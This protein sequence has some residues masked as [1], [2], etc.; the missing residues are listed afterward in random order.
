M[1]RGTIAP[2]TAWLCALA[3][4]ATA[5]QTGQAR[6]TTSLTA[7]AGVT[8]AQHTDQSASPLLFAGSGFAERLDYERAG[9]RWTTTLGISSLIR[10]DVSRATAAAPVRERS[11]QGGLAWTAVRPLIDRARA[12]LAAG[13]T[14]DARGTLLAHHYDDPAATV[15]WFASAFATVG[16]A[17]RWRWMV[18]GGTAILRAS[19]PLVGVAHRPY[20]D[21]RIEQAAPALR[22]VTVSD[23]RAF[24]ASAAVETAPARPIGLRAEVNVGTFRYSDVQSMRAASAGFSLGVV[25]RFG[26]PRP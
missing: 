15:S 1:F 24:D 5:A 9:R 10:D 11:I 3:V 16:P 17:V 4:H 12:T 22:L 2:T 19:A 18:P 14:L 20:S 23:L 7:S 25:A 21:V 8:F 13:L 6:F 26:A